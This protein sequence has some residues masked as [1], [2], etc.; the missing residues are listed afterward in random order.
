MGIRVPITWR[1]YILFWFLKFITLGLCFGI[2]VELDELY[3]HV[4]NSFILWIPIIVL[5]FLAFKFVFPFIDGLSAY[6]Y[7]RIILRTPVEFKFAYN[8]RFL[9]IPNSTGKWFPMKHIKEVPYHERKYVF[10]KEISKIINSL[11]N[12]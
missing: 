6:A 5:I 8:C 2:V 10:E 7:I 4:D 3:F 9:F 1:G 11:S 12:K